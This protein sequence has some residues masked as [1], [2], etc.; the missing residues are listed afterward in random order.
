MCVGEKSAAEGEEL[1][2]SIYGKR[3]GKRRKNSPSKEAL[4]AQVAAGEATMREQELVIT[5][6]TATLALKEKAAKAAGVVRKVA[7]QEVISTK[8]ALNL[9]ADDAATA[10]Q[11]A[12]KIRRRLHATFR[13]L[14]RAVR[15]V[16]YSEINSRRTALSKLLM[17]SQTTSAIDQVLGEYGTM[18]LRRVNEALVRYEAYATRDDAA[19]EA[20][21]IYFSHSIL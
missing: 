9:A 17:M 8:K 15:A 5:E 2:V 1:L 11:S 7:V 21:N 12:S 3:G 18:A 13:Q 4:E 16:A 20:V 10:E 6:R 14:K 19:V